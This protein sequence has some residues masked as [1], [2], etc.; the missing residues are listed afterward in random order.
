MIRLVDLAGSERL[1]Q[2]G[3]K[4]TTLKETKKINLSL[5]CLGSVL[6][7]LAEECEGKRKRR[8]KGVMV[9]ANAKADEKKE[10]ESYVFCRLLEWK[11]TL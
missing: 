4:G 2:S 1:S 7:A 8:E 3:A 9:S 5:T 11:F 6:S 10:D